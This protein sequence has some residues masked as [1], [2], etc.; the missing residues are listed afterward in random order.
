MVLRPI[1]MNIALELYS[2]ISLSV[3]FN[4]VMMVTLQYRGLLI[5]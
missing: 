2:S 4:D 5:S 1:N 3:Y